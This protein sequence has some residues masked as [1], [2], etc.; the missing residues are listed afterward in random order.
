M[1]ILDIDGTLIAR[2]SETIRPAV[3]EALHQ[4]QRQGIKLLIAT[5]RAY[6]FIQQDVHDTYL[7]SCFVSFCQYSFQFF[8]AVK[9]T[10]LYGSQTHTGSFRYLTV[11][12][13]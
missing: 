8:P 5:G 2:G 4:A 10:A 13:P 11:F 7:S 12:E 6:Y 1:L 9:N 3:V